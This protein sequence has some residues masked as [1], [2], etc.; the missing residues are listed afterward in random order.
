MGDY[1]RALIKDESKQHLDIVKKI[2]ALLKTGELVDD[3]TVIDVVQQFSNEA[4]KSLNGVIF[5]GVPRTISQ[6]EMMTKFIN[7]DLVVNFLNRDEILL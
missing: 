3:R 1:F 7:I 4:D 2:K 6:A 5:D